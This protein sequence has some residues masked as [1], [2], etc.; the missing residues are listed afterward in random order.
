[1]ERILD[2]TVPIRDD[3]RGQLVHERDAC[4][5]DVADCVLQAAVFGEVRYG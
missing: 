5:A 1:V 2:G 4:D 3:L